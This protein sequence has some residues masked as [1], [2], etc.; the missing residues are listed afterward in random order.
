MKEYIKQIY[1]EGL[2]LSV[3]KPIEKKIKKIKNKELKRYCSI[4]FKVIYMLLAI[5]ISIILFLATYP[6]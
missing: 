4:L 3:Y 2:G 1:D 6:L 5:T